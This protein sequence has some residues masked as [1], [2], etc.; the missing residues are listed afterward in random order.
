MKT[1]KSLLILLFLGIIAT[2]HAQEASVKSE[3]NIN[4]N[5]DKITYYQQRGREDAT[6]ELTFTAQTKA[7]EKAFWKEQKEYEKELKK[8]NRKAYQA[9]IASKEDVYTTHHSHC[10]S[11]CQHSDAFYGHA[12]FYYYEYD[13][14]NYQRRPSTTS[15]RTQIGVR[16]HSLRLGLF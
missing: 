4:V 2:A 8:K 10:D 1:I 12:G 16:A 7:E 5:T 14:K 15:V 3:T 9:Y 11:H 6:Y 13:Q